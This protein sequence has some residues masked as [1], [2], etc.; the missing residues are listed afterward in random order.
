M[1]LSGNTVLITG[2]GSGIELA[3]AKEFARLDNQVIIAGRSPQ[4]LDIA[5]GKGLKT[6]IADMSDLVSIENLAEQVIRDFPALNVVIHNA[7]VSRI[8]NLLEGGDSKI[9]EE[10]I[11]TNLLGPMR[12]TN[13]LLPH[14]LTQETAAIM[15]VSSGLAFLPNAQAPTYSA[16]KAA[17]HSYS[18]SLRYQLKN[19]AIE[20]PHGQR[21]RST[22][23]VCGR[24]QS[25]DF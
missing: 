17:L 14:L 12:L 16:T 23:A 11:T 7:G 2:G 15:T 22:L 6:A 4:K 1:K 13:A 9:A 21:C 24:K 5:A 20:V 19:T 10:I 18:Q 25:A 8:E 3:L